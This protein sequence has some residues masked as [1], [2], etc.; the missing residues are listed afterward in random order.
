MS[1]WEWMLI[2]WLGAAVVT[3]LLVGAMFRAVQRRPAPRRPALIG[4][5]P[6]RRRR[7]E[8]STRP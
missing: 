2:A 5:P 6:G 7:P 1:W 4:T 3:T 8:A